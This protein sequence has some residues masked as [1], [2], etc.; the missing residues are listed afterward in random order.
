LKIAE[1]WRA[2]VLSKVAHYVRLFNALLPFSFNST[3]FSELQKNYSLRH[4]SPKH[5]K[6]KYNEKFINKCESTFGYFFIHYLLLWCAAMTS[7]NSLIHIIFLSFVVS[8]DSP[9][10]IF[11]WQLRFF[12]GSLVKGVFWLDWQIFVI[13]WGA[14]SLME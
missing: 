10:I 3:L 9:W 6:S 13:F 8:Y 1:H 7:F 11:R 14:L 2:V 12:R 4:E 5:T